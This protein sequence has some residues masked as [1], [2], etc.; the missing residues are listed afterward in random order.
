[1][2]GG[3]DPREGEVDDRGSLQETEHMARAM[4]LS[5]LT[6]E[7]KHPRPHVHVVE[8]IWDQN[9]GRPGAVMNPPTMKSLL[10]Q[11]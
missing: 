2:E 1:M 6:G 7:G 9:F 10:R 8:P 5:I 11:L 4:D 3:E